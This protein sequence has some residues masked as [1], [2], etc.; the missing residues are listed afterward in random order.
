MIVILDTTFLEP[1]TSVIFLFLATAIIKSFRDYGFI[2]F[3]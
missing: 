1:D 3:D 2:V